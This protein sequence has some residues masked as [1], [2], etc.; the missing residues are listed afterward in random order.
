MELQVTTQFFTADE[1]FRQNCSTKFSMKV[2]FI[3]MIIFKNF[4]REVK[5]NSFWKYLFINEISNHSEPA[6][7]S[8]KAAIGGIL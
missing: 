8:G 4:L 7:Q 6:L 5:S 2:W 3:L 1:N